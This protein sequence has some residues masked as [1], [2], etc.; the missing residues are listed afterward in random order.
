MDN[1]ANR[2]NPKKLTYTTLGKNDLKY[3][4]ER[5]NGEKMIMQFPTMALSRNKN[6]L[7]KMS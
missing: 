1:Q 4:R 7:I 2:K 6:I 3:Q 5:Y